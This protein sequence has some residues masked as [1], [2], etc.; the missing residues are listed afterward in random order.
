MCFKFLCEGDKLRCIS[1]CCV[2]VERKLLYKN[3]W[4]TVLS[5]VEQA[6]IIKWLMNVYSMTM[7][8]L[9]FFFTGTRNGSKLLLQCQNCI[10]VLKLHSIL[11]LSV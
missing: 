5:S 4:I 6:Y 11:M 9:S 8:Q 2:H 10:S 3:E 1:T 7:Q